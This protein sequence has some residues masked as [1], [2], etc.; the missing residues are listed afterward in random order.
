MKIMAAPVAIP[1]TYQSHVQPKFSDAYQIMVTIDSSRKIEPNKSNPRIR[2]II[3][4]KTPAS[5]NEP[6]IKGSHGE[7]AAPLM[8]MSAV[9]DA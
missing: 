8:M 2:N 7:L 1:A 4:A 5:D 3:P 6:R 9:D